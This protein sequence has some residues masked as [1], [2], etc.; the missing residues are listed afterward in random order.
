MRTLILATASAIALGIAG[1]GPL[2][3]QNASANTAANPAPAAPQTPAPAAMPNPTAGG[4]MPGTPQPD[5][6]AAQQHNPSTVSGSNQYG[7][8]QHY[9]HMSA[10]E[11]RGAG[12]ERMSRS[13]VK[14]ID[15][16]RDG[17]Y[18]GR[19]DGI[20]GRETHQA[21]RLYQQRNGLPVTGRLD[22]STL[23]SLQ[24]TGTGVG[25]TMP[26]NS[27]NGIN[28]GAVNPAPSSNAG[29]SGTP[30]ASHPQPPAGQRQ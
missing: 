16:R 9:R 11:R 25:S 23:A 18:R 13:E 26:S 7:M 27:S 28:T 12:W 3:A 8:T 20:A 19:I 1:A 24:G 6:G 2:Y 10:T 22:Q 5:T 15:L 17:F 14:Q 21:L 4:N 29:T 30:G